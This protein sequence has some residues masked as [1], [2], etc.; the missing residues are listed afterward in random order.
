M[1]PVLGAAALAFVLSAAPPSAAAAPAPAP[2]PASSPATASPP[3][4][5]EARQ[6][7]GKKAWD[8]LYLRFSA[9]KAADY[10]DADRKAVAAALMEASRALRDDL[11]LSVACAEKSAQLDPTVEA[12]L[13][14]GD[15]NLKLKQGA[16][17]ASAYEKAVLLSPTN[18]RALVARAD[19]AMQEGEPELAVSLYSKVPAKAAES[20]AAQEK[21]AKAK[22]AAQER[23]KALAELAQAD[24]KVVVGANAGKPPED[25]NAVGNESV[26]TESMRALCG[27]V[28][29]CMPWEPGAKTCDDEVADQC[30]KLEGQTKV[31]RKA[32]DACVAGLGKATCE[33]FLGGARSVTELSGA[34]KTVE[35]ALDRLR[36]GAGP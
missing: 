9:A 21:L 4:A 25:P 15:A 3:A 28:R 23:A 27:L 31:T 19:L 26:C 7:A 29:R 10:K 24:R 18:G 6:L 5:A 30:A 34:C 16:A 2:S 33:K 36:D 11:A 20:K 8:E 14:A 13:A 17:A 12:W 35:E 32:M 22:V 1:M